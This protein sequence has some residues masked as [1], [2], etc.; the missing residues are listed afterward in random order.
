[1]A[2]WRIE[3]NVDLPDDVQ[4]NDVARRVKVESGQNVI[5][6]QTFLVD[7][8]SAEQAAKKGF[9]TLTLNE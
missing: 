1:M 2:R 5:P 6:L 3:L 4:A 9:D 8:R 7:N